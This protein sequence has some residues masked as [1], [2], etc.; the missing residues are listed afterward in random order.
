[1]SSPLPDQARAAVRLV[2][3]DAGRASVSGADVLRR[4]LDTGDLPAACVAERALGLAAMYRQDLDLALQHVRAAIR[5]GRL[6]APRLAAEARMTLAFILIRRAR[7]QQAL[8]EI[9]RALVDLD[10]V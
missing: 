5:H 2:D 3:V 7:A 10:G 1:M 4:A 6:V 8:R 9:D